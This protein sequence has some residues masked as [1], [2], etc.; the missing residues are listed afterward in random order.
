MIV[1]GATKFYETEDIVEVFHIGKEKALKIMH[2]PELRA[3]MIGNRL[4]VPEERLITLLN[5]G[6]RI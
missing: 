3:S 1:F 2:M 5:S 6:K 4:V